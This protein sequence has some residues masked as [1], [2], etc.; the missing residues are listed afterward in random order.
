MEPYKYNICIREP[1]QPPVYLTSTMDI[2]NN[3]MELCGV[4]TKVLDNQVQTLL[5]H[6]THIFNC[7]VVNYSFIFHLA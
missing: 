7:A 4:L 6:L 2:F 5:S 1:R 3:E